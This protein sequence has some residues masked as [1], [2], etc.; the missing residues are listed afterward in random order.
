MA[1]RTKHDIPFI[2]R[3]LSVLTLQDS[4]FWSEGEVKHYLTWF[5]TWP[6]IAGP[7]QRLYIERL[8]KRIWKTI[9]EQNSNFPGPTSKEKKIRNWFDDYR[10][11]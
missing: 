8:C 1:T 3:V 2:D 11:Q 6:I 4:H 10:S 5:R 9:L 7:F